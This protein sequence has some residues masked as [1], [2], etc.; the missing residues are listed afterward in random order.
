MTNEPQR[1]SAG[2]L[3]KERFGCCFSAGVSLVMLTSVD[4]FTDDGDVLVFF[5]CLTPVLIPISV[6]FSLVFLPCRPTYL[7]LFGGW[8]KSQN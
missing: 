8:G 3:P 6:L 2:R 7:A 1:T 4:L 5:N